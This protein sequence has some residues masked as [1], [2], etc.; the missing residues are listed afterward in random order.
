M[1]SG[2]SKIAETIVGVFVPPACREEVLGDLYERYRSASQYGLDA[3]RTLPLVIA[4]R[5]RRTANPQVLLMQ[6]FALYE[7]F[8]GAAWFAN[9]PFLSE[10]WG[11]PRLAIPTAIALLGLLLEDAY[12]RPGARSPLQLTRGPLFGVLFALASQGVLRMT[13]WGLALPSWILYYGCAFSFV[14]SSALRLLFPP[15][16]DRLQGINVPADWLKPAAAGAPKSRF[17]TLAV[18]VLLLAY[19]VW[20]RS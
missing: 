2:P 11:L 4:S 7:A 8:L 20:K 1:S 10:R 16:V 14:L 17:L 5:I 15:A 12:A 3:A 9:R 6:A 19:I 13:D 18:V